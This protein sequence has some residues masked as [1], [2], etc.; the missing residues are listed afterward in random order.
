MKS[1]SDKCWPHAK[2]LI[3]F[4]TFPVCDAAK[5]APISRKFC[6]DECRYL[7]QRVCRQ[8]FQLARSI[9]VIKQYVPSC[10]TLPRP[11]SPEYATCWRLPSLDDLKYR[12][13]LNCF[14]NSFIIIS[15]ENL[16]KHSNRPFSPCPRMKTEY[17]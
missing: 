13:F 12:K 15:N 14:L 11:D 7:E 16:C 1:V 6:Q 9:D 8:E 17:S 10:G 3:C 2:V 5:R 4:H